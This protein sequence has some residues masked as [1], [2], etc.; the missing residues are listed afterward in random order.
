MIP[1]FATWN[2]TLVRDHSKE[3]SADTFSFNSNNGGSRYLAGVIL[4]MPENLV[5][6]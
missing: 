2:E 5:T 4:I 1:A 3:T 6:V